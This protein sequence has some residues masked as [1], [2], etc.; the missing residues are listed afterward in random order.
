MKIAD[1]KLGTVYVDIYID[2]FS[3]VDSYIESGFID[4]TEA[5]LTSEEIDYLNDKYSDLVQEYAWE[6]GETRNHN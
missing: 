3:A 2:N 1:D 4:A 5:D 6:S